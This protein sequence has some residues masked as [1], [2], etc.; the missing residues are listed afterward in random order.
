MFGYIV[1]SFQIFK[2]FALVLWENSINI[3]LGIALYLLIA[4]GSM[5]ISTVLKCAIHARG[6]FFHLFVPS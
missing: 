2:L 1:E 6:A 4:L 3:S 5:E